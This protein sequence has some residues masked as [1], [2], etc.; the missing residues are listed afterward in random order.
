MGQCGL[1]IPR[2]IRLM[3]VPEFP[4]RGM[5]ENYGQRAQEGLSVWLPTKPQA[6][7]DQMTVLC[8]GTMK[9]TETPVPSAIPWKG[10]KGCMHDPMNALSARALKSAMMQNLPTSVGRISVGTHHRSLQSFA[11]TK[12]KTLYLR[13]FTK[14]R[15]P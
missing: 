11:H 3:Q 1:R 7:P 8:L 5:G 13:R 4:S 6:R 10:M 2:D 12:V 14:E 9:R 15:G